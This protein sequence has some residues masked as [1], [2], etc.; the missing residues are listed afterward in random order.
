MNVHTYQSM[1]KVHEI[2]G[3]RER[4]KCI[5]DD[6]LS[7]GEGEGRVEEDDCSK[8]QWLVI[9]LLSVMWNWTVQWNDSR[10]GWFIA[11]IF[12]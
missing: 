5:S 7:A 8:R 11:V 4:T 2:E 1:C 12:V 10:T 9:I 3:T 6:V